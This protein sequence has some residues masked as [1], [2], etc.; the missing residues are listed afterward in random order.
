MKRNGFTLIELLVVMV[1]IAVLSGLMLPAVRKS[2]TKAMINLA[3]SEMAAIAGAISMA[4]LDCGYYVQIVD[5]SNIDKTTVKIYGSDGVLQDQVTGETEVTHW[6]PPYLLS[7][8]NYFDP[9]GRQYRMEYIQAERV[10]KI[11]SAGIDGQFGTEKDLELRF[12]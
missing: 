9:W 3:E 10:M 1:I 12:F 8:N 6:E 4:K 5:L 2:R 11:I 7:R